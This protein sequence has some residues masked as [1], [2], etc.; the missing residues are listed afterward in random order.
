MKMK[1]TRRI[2]RRYVGLGRSR[3]RPRLSSARR[4]GTR[5]MGVAHRRGRDHLKLDGQFLAV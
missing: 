2:Y 1:I 5:P 4:L 3:V